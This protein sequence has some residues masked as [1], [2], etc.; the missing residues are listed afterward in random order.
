LN[1]ELYESF[2][3]N[4]TFR[5]IASISFL[6][7]KKI[8]RVF[9]PLKQSLHG[10]CLLIDFTSTDSAGRIKLFFQEKKEYPVIKK[11]KVGI[12]K[13]SL[14]PLPFKLPRL[15]LPLASKNFAWILFLSVLLLIGRFITQKQ[16]V[17]NEN[18]QSYGIELAEEKAENNEYEPEIFFEWK[19]E[20]FSPQRIVISGSDVLCFASSENQVFN[21]APDGSSSIFKTDFHFKEAVSLES[22]AIVFLTEEGEFVLME[23]GKLGTLFFLEKLDH[24]FQFNNMSSFASSV[25]FWDQPSMQVVRYSKD[26]Y[27]SIW[28]APYNWLKKPNILGEI[29]P[30]FMT[31]DESIWFLSADAIIQ[32]YKGEFVKDFP[33]DISPKINSFTKIFTLKTSPYLYIMDP[34]EGR[35]ILVDKENA[36]IRGE[37]QN[38]KFKNLKHL[39]L[40]EQGVV[41]LLGEAKIYRVLF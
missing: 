17:Q 34:T 5:S 37:L 35:I 36:E 26:D 29:K 39:A 3:Q 33:I 11:I 9:A 28:S 10:F 20:G 15:S 1:Q 21:I 8:S 13:L 16:G 14:P 30:F 27:S 18:A 25:Y 24:E 2:L 41:Y 19:D 40:T 38:D 12:A 7:E 31:V 22:G 6:S 32:Y 23:Q 4:G